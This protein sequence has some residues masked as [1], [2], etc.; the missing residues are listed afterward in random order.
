MQTVL[1]TGGTSGIGLAT[2]ARLAAAGYRPVLI[3]RDASRGA[4]ATAEVPEAIYLAGDVTQA[5]A[6]PDL[7][8]QAAA[9]GD[10]AGLVTAAGQYREGLLADETPAQLA[11]LF[12]VNVYGTIYA[13]QAA[14]PYLRRTRGSVVVVASDAA[15]NGNIAASVYAA[16]KGAVTAFARSWSLEMAPYGVRVNAVLPGD[17]DTPLTRAQY[18]TT[19]RDD[20]AAQYPLGRIATAAEVA[21][22]IAFLLS[23]DAAFVTGAWW[24]VDGGLTAW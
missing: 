20:M 7:L 18:E 12:A 22:V 21:A 2:A 16:T 15:V 10:I 3:G 5:D 11:E 4:A 19:A 14:A 9:Y 17:T 6:W 1:I 8:A 13:C 23:P 24:T